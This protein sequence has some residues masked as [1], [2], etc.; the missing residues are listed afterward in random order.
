MPS[1]FSEELLLRP[2]ADRHLEATWNYSLSFR[3]GIAN[4]CPRKPWESKD[5][6]PELCHFDIFDS[7]VAQL[8]RSTGARSA[9]LSLTGGTWKAH[10]GPSS[11]PVGPDGL[12]I[13]AE[14]EVPHLLLPAYD[15]SPPLGTF[16]RS[17]EVGH[18]WTALRRGLGGVLGL[19]LMPSAPY[20]PIVHYP[21]VR[22]ED[23]ATI[24]FRADVARER[25]GLNNLYAWGRLVPCGLLRH[26][27]TNRSSTC[28]GNIGPRARRGA[29]YFGIGN[30]LEPG[31]FFGKGSMFTA[32]RI[33]ATASPACRSWRFRN[34]CVLTLESTMATFLRDAVE[35]M[36]FS[37][38]AFAS[39]NGSTAHSPNAPPMRGFSLATLLRAPPEGKTGDA[40]SENAR[41]VEP[42]RRATN[43]KQ[44]PEDWDYQRIAKQSKCGDDV[45]VDVLGHL[46]ACPFAQ[47]SV[48]RTR[49]P[50]M[51]MSKSEN[52]SRRH[53]LFATEP[54]SRTNIS[55]FCNCS[56]NYADQSGLSHSSENPRKPVRHQAQVVAAI[57]VQ[58]LTNDVASVYEQHVNSKDDAERYSSRAS[59]RLSRPWASFT[60]S[61]ADPETAWTNSASSAAATWAAYGN[62]AP[63]SATN[64]F[65]F[66][67]TPIKISKRLSPI[68]AWRGV[69]V[70]DITLRSSAFRIA[71]TCSLDPADRL[72]PT[73][74][75]PS[76]VSPQLQPNNFLRLLEPLPGAIITPFLSTLRVNISTRTLE[77]CPMACNF[78]LNGSD[79]CASKVPLRTLRDFPNHFHW[80]EN[81][82][83]PF[84]SEGSTPTKL[85]FPDHQ[86]ANL[87]LEILLPLEIPMKQIYRCSTSGPIHMQLSYEYSPNLIKMEH[88]PPDV[89]RGFEL[90]PTEGSIVTLPVP[91]KS[92][93]G[94]WTLPSA[95][96]NEHMPS[97]FSPGAL[98]VGEGGRARGKAQ[99]GKEVTKEAVREAGKEG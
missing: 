71:P 13:E 8:L 17:A 45:A 99:G 33:R 50:V 4:F 58:H 3:P 56:A 18:A 49:L 15:S 64:G 22:A 20:A 92:S 35:P 7:S 28:G 29:G 11:V 27:R 68:A 34:H 55:M 23:E 84:F 78:A 69:V 82:K 88:W 65:W 70:I 89:A 40:A 14:F 38:L 46:R 61:R 16:S 60:S 72:D 47:H 93:R 77:S 51:I 5:S 43:A 94:D 62:L 85:W 48:L 42:L 74:R 91:L 39:P 54:F 81:A 21:P 32:L 31:V 90:P 80:F 97:Y 57:D 52:L 98:L 63:R 25:P 41:P 96:F 26:R 19:A 6:P 76:L 86:R 83:V 2:V 79:S 44:H 36:S 95:Y 24:R 59:A 67:A 53:T 30:L 87:V 10:W 9:S 37:E 12:R 66:D 75:H 73:D 1:V